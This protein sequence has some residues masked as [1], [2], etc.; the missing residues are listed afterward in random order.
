MF[1]VILFFFSTELIYFNTSELLNSYMDIYK[2]FLMALVTIVFLYLTYLFYSRSKI[3]NVIVI[4]CLAAPYYLMMVVLTL[5][6]FNIP[7][8]PDLFY[9][10]IGLYLIFTEFKP[11][12]NFISG[13]YALL[14]FCVTLFF[15]YPIIYKN[16]EFKFL[17]GSTN[18]TRTL[19]KFDMSFKNRKGEVFKTSDF[20]GKTV[21][22]DMWSSSCGGCIQSMPDFEKL[23]KHYKNNPDFKIISLFCPKKP[24]Q[25]F[26]WF[27]TYIKDEFPYDIDYYYINPEEF[28]KLGVYKFPEFLLINKQNSLEYKGI[29]QYMPYVKDNIYTQLNSINETQ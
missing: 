1:G 20:S 28:K 22:I 13:K 3:K 2:P 18:K 16:L 26:D 21:C 8:M 11:K 29:I 24:N 15:I 7:R 9:M 4:S 19:G 10:T 27:L 12:P 17:K 23:N 14:V 25:T 5:T 6:S